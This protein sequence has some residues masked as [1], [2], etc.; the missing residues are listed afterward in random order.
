MSDTV[1]QQGFTRRSG[2]LAVQPNGDFWELHYSSFSPADYPFAITHSTLFPARQSHTV[3]TDFSKPSWPVPP[4]PAHPSVENSYTSWIWGP[5]VYSGKDI[6]SL[7][8]STPR[9]LYDILIEAL[10]YFLQ[11]GGPNRPPKRDILPKASDGPPTGPRAVSFTQQQP[12]ARA[13][14]PDGSSQQSKTRAGDDVY[15]RLTNALS[16]R[17]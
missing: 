5:K 1:C 13:R 4:Q 10:S 16:E 7:C 14:S 15:T 17:G 9:S 8:K 11:V 3:T 6:D 12:N 2:V